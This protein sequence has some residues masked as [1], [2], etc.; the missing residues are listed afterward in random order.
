MATQLELPPVVRIRNPLLQTRDR[1]PP[2]PSRPLKG[3]QRRYRSPINDGMNVHLLS[4]Q[5]NNPPWARRPLGGRPVLLRTLACSPEID[6]HNQ[7]AELHLPSPPRREILGAAVLHHGVGQVSAMDLV[8]V[9]SGTGPFPRAA[10]AVDDGVVRAL[11]VW[12]RRRTKGSGIWFQHK[13]GLRCFLV[14]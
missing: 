2:D 8:L 13:N 14:G 10:G 1:A 7:G 9:G 5:C 4:G 12:L 3:S 6:L 11:C